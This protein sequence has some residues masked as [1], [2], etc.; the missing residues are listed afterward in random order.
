MNILGMTVFPFIA[1]PAFSLIGF[2]DKN[3]LEI[4]MKERKKLIPMWTKAMLKA[5]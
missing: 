1:K 3:R 2:T 5:K 4:R